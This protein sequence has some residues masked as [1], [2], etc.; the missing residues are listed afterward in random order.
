M[1]LISNR[2]SLFATSCLEADVDL[3][4]RSAFYEGPWGLEG[5]YDSFLGYLAACRHC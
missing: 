3:S 2:R 5:N 1:T 4:F